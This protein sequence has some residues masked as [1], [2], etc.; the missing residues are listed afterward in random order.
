MND[1]VSNDVQV[2]RW[3][4][5]VGRIEETLDKATVENLVDCIEP[6]F[7]S[8]LTW[9]WAVF[10]RAIYQKSGGGFV[11]IQICVSLLAVINSKLPEVG[12]STIEFV[13][14]RLK[15]GLAEVS[16][17]EVQHAA[18]V[19][20]ECYR[21]RIVS[22]PL[23]VQLLVSLMSERRY[24]HLLLELLFDV[25]PPLQIDDKNAVT[26]IF[27]ELF[28][29]SD[30]PSISSEI[31]KLTVWRQMGWVKLVNGK[32][33]K[34]VRIPKKFD[35]IEESD[36]ISHDDID[37]DEIGDEFDPT[38]RYSVPH[39]LDIVESMRV[40]YK[41]FLA[42]L[43]SDEEE[44]GED[45]EK[46]PRHKAEEE[47]TAQVNEAMQQNAVKNEQLQIKRKVYL[48]IVS[49]VTSNATAHTLLKLADEV[50]S[51]NERIVMNT[52]IDYTGMERT[53]NRDLGVL[54]EL[55]CRGRP[56]FIPLVEN[57]F[58]KSYLDCH[59]FTIHRMI[60]LA[61]LFAY[62]LGRDV[63]GWHVLCTVRLTEEDTTSAQ[64]VFIK[65]LME[66]LA[67]NMSHEGL[68]KKL[69]E[70][71]VAES[72]SELF[73]ADTLDHAEFCYAFF[74][75]INLGFLCERLRGA[76]E[77]MAEE[78]ERKKAEELAAIKMYEQRLKKKRRHKHHSSSSSE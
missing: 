20:T 27:Q 76:I 23:V 62:L 28:K 21:Q 52:C 70:P 9:T 63:I 17:R 26:V 65:Y 34:Y 18:T 74:H 68:V 51:D 56:S 7:R 58:V 36:Q 46:P 6:L 49:N 5:Y 22:A 64:R 14:F 16:V 11:H 3:R 33:M 53:F 32:K 41:Q 44:E 73:L 35:L 15:K 39:K 12:K 13:L 75:E 24:L 72:T 8:Y 45:E 77:K 57:G 60:N 37:F 29:Y 10:A 38:E 30:D 19:I 40:E 43:F 61:C 54:I 71:D 2:K 31:Q 50:G 42:G 55:M 1:E 4:K 48:T 66:E 59:K 78:E 67:K 25:A 47:S 69:A